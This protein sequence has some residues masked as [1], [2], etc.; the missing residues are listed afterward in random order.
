MFLVFTSCAG[1]Q[2]VKS[3]SKLPY[4]YNQLK[5]YD[6]DEMLEIVQER[7][8]LYEGTKNLERLNEVLMLILARPNSDNILERVMAKLRYG[9]ETDE[10]WQEMVE[11]V[12]DE[13]VVALKNETTAVN[14]QLAYLTALQNLILEFKPEFRK[15]GVDPRF[16]FAM[17]ERISE[18]KL[19]V[20]DEVK[21][22]AKLN[23]ISIPK[24]PSA[25]ADAVIKEVA[26]TYKPAADR[27]KQD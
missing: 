23:L 10:Q 16:E 25:I 8:E 13:A 9:V 5:L 18:A 20:S 27:L 4:S 24:S 12:V 1:K 14:D 2:V 22:D 19:I 3:E 17:I 21:A 15:K 6:V 11:T 7:L 26:A